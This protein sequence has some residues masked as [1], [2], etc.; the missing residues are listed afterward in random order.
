MGNIYS[1]SEPLVTNLDKRVV[2]PTVFRQNDVTPEKD[3]LYINYDCR[4]YCCDKLFNTSDYKKYININNKY[5]K[6]KCSNEEKLELEKLCFEYE[7]ILFHI[8]KGP[9][10]IESA[11]AKRLKFNEEAR[12]AIFKEL[13]KTFP[14][15]TRDDIR[16]IIPVDFGNDLI[17]GIAIYF[18]PQWKWGTMHLKIIKKNYQVVNPDFTSDG[19]AKTVAEIIFDISKIKINPT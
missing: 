1:K 6:E 18:L 12:E 15:A 16:I 9:L 10:S 8:H 2:I 7:Q 14:K 4:R 5:W 11:T 17:Y 3:K 13:K 19:T